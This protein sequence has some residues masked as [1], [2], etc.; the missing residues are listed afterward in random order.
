MPRAEG[1]CRRCGEMSWARCH[2]LPLRHLADAHPYQ[3]R[4]TLREWLHRLAHRL[5]LTSGHVDHEKQ[6]G[7][8]MLGLRCDVCGELMHPIPSAYQDS[9]EQLYK[10]FDEV[11]R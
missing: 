5:W 8:W 3:P 11:T 4:P 1:P 7:V 2:L 9:C 6:N 10:M